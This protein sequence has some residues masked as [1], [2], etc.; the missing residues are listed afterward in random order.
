MLR[1]IL[2]VIVLS[3]QLVSAQTFRI[4]HDRNNLAIVKT[5]SYDR[6]KYN[7]ITDLSAL[8]P[9]IGAPQLP[10]YLYRVRLQPGETV[11]DLH[12]DRVVREEIDGV[13]SVYPRQPL[14]NQSADNQFVSPDEKAYASED[15]TPAAPVR[16]LGTGRFNGITIAHFAVSPVQYIPSAGKLYFVKSVQF[17]IQTDNDQQPGVAPYLSYDAVRASDFVDRM[18]ENTSHPLGKT[19]SVHDLSPED[20]TS[21]LIDRYV[22]ITT[23]SLKDAFEPLVDWK[24]R[25]GVPTVVRTLEWIRQNFPEGTDDAERMRNFI[26]W[27]YQKRGT[28]YVMFGGD[29]DIIP[30]RIIHT[31]GYTFPVDY[32]FADL[33]GTWNANNND[34]F[35]EAEDN[36]DAY[37]EVYV[38]RIPVGNVEDVQRFITKLF[39]Y[40]KLTELNSEEKY[41]ANVLYMASNLSNVNDGRDLIM[42]NIDPVINPDFERRMITESGEIGNSAEVPKAE[43]N[44][45]YGLIFSESH[46]AYFTI[47]P[48]GT[49]SN[50]F[51]YELD[52]LTNSMPPVW[53]IASCNTNDIIKR[54]FSE[55]Y[56]LSK[57]GGGVAYI[58]NTDYEYPFSGIYLERDFFD[59]VFNQGYPN[60]AEALFLSRYRYLGFLNGEGATRI[61]V[62]ATLE[63]GD[64]EMPIWTE[65]PARMQVEQQIVSMNDAPALQITVTDSAGSPLE[66]AVAT[67][68]RENQVYKIG[69]SDPAG[70]VLFSLDDVHT[71]SAMVTVS[72]H[73]YIPYE[74]PATLAHDT[75]QLSVTSWQS[76]EIYGNGNKQCEPGESFDLTFSIRNDGAIPIEEGLVLQ[77]VAETPGVDFASPQKELREEILPGMT[78]SSP[79]FSFTISPDF[80]ADTTALVNIY[81][82]MNDRVVD[83]GEITFPIRL[84]M[85]TLNGQ[86]VETEQTGSENVSYLNAR[87]MN[88]GKGM[89]TGAYFTIRPAD[90]LCRTE[91]DSFYIGNLAGGAVSDDFG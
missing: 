34:I 12:I 79:E 5:D 63:L 35:G 73:N 8:E 36:V 16:F 65:N 47:R 80:P 60:I 30:T 81:Y 25:R 45:N 77:L 28:K 22:I 53:F 85:L 59:L 71:D 26:R 82:L 20:L 41:P 6:I 58:G 67:L 33:D 50:I 72:K 51:S 46:G 78:V 84:P 61:I 74:Q 17:S 3:A 48:G 2:L 18:T 7:G 1:Y 37:P 23:E 66:G 87:F 9:A 39:K 57:H 14:W 88:R 76:N 27:S 15:L 31:G 44:K 75:Y 83:H 32:Y 86:S 49:N 4:E 24:I 11:T 91:Q 64:A 69:Y 70:T 62:F 10:V 13:F 40:E 29:T 42:K 19:A 56:I 55:M 38:S 21:G 89:A 52:D 90:S 68:Y 43:L 54:S